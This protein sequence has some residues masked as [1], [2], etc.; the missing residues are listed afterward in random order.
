MAG[1]GDRPHELPGQ[2]AIPG[3]GAE[4]N[5]R[6]ASGSFLA[7]LAGQ[8]EASTNRGIASARSSGLSGSFRPEF[9]SPDSRIASLLLSRVVCQERCPCPHAWPRPQV[10][11]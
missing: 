3:A 8:S 2:G 6:T 1:Q 5:N 10:F 11:L 9:R 4:A 7:G